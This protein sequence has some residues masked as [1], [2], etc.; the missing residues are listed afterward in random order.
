MS[1]TTSTNDTGLVTVRPA[2]KPTAKAIARALEH[3]SAQ[4]LM[5][6]LCALDWDVSVSRPKWWRE[7]QK[8]IGRERIAAAK[9]KAKAS[10]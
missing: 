10:R 7:E 6:A 5:E 4:Q 1:K 9:A 8:R 3:A 2:R